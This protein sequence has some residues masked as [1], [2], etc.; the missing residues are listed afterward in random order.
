MEKLNKHF[1]KEDIQMAS[2]YTNRGSTSPLIRKMQ[3][4]T[5]MN[6]HFI[7]I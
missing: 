7:S 5:T 6:Y 4:K 1:S 2:R 3:I